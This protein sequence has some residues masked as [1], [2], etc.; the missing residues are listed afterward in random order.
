MGMLLIS[1]VALGDPRDQARRMHDRL[2]GTPP[3]DAM[4]DAMELALSSGRQ[5]DAALYAMDGAPGEPANG[6]FYTVVLKNWVSPWTNEAQDRFVALNDYTATVIGLVRDEADFR[7]VLSEDVIYIGQGAGIP[8]YSNSNNDHYEVLEASGA[9]LGDSAVLVRR[10]QSGVTGL[11][12]AG[13]AGVISTRAAA[14]AYFVDGTNRAMF[15][16]TLLNHLCVD[17]EQL[18]DGTRPTD[19]IRQDISR[20]PGGDST[21]FLNSCVDCHSGM[22]P[23]AQ[24]FAYYDFPY[25]NEDEAPGL[26]LELRKDQGQLVYTPGSVQGKYLINSATFPTGYITPSDQ[27]TNYWRLGDNSARVGWRNSAS[28]SDGVNLAIN[29][30]YS[31]GAGAASLGRELANTDAFSQCQVKK[32][33]RTVCVREPGVPDTAAFSGFVNSF[34]TTHN[35]K[36]VFAE[37]AAYCSAPLGEE[38]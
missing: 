11:P 38:P 28:D 36:G 25:P 3:S 20:S 35:I 32:V 18:K 31:E 9:N 10:T 33:F 23:L 22:D 24:A 12:P 15:R 26:A 7:E 27:W 29:S 30:A 5:S 37:V 13:V 1:N 8:A 19:R 21:L 14:R 4:L 34:N 2:T 16:F 17:M 6:N